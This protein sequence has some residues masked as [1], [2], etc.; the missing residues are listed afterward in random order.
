MIKVYDGEVFS[1]DIAEYDRSLIL[2]QC[3]ANSK[4]SEQKL[5]VYDGEALIGAMS[6]QD[7]LAD[8][9][10]EPNCLYFGEDLFTRAREY[11]RKEGNRQSCLPVQSR[12]GEL[13]FLLTFAENRIFDEFRD[14][15]LLHEYWEMDFSSD[16]DYLDFTLLERANGFYFFEL[17]EY[18]Y[19]LARLILRKYPEK[20]ICFGDKRAKIF[21]PKSEVKIYESTWEF[22]E[23]ENPAGYLYV[24]SKRNQAGYRKTMP[25]LTGHYGSIQLMESLLWCRKKT[26]MGN[27]NE[28]KTIFLMDF[29]TTICGLV[30]IMKYGYAWVQIAHRRGWIPVMK[31]D[32]FPNQYL[33]KTGENMWEYF[34]EPVSEISVEEAMQSAQVISA[35]ENALRFDD[36]FGNMYLAEYETQ[37]L[38]ERE[39]H[40][41]KTFNRIVRV[42]QTLET[43]LHKGLPP[44]FWAADNRIL[45]VVARGTDYRKEVSEKRTGYKNAAQIKDIRQVIRRCREAAASWG[46]NYIFVATEDESYFRLF[47]GEFNE[48]L[49][50]IGQKRLEIDETDEKLYISDKLVWKSGERKAFAMQY[51]LSIYCLSKCKVLISN[52]SCGAEQLAKMWNAGQYEYTEIV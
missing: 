34:F 40:P 17:E 13:M 48:A 45:G 27:K 24:N 12:G 1:F 8:K 31:L 35:R 14:G 23:I 20:Q 49:L 29:S 33:E 30:D 41:G 37:F 3:W 44:Q 2:E 38:E 5:L 22:K 32:G 11:F 51:L 7:I 42:R 9:P 36:I 46:C 52:M 25:Y 21:F 18:T 4:C 47:S 19:E 16:M 43:Y 28:G 15:K 10:I 6:Y 26:R 39:Y 50:S